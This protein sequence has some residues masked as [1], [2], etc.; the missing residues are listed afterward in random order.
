M[1]CPHCADLL[2]AY[3]RR[4]AELEEEVEFL[5]RELG[6]AADKLA[7]E[8]IS[9]AM[10]NRAGASRPAAART[11]AAL[12]AAKGRPLSRFDILERVPP[13]KE[14]HAD[15]LDRGANIASVWISCARKGLGPGVI[16]TVHGSGYRLTPEGMARVAAIVEG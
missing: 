15:P 3:D 12:Y 6:L 11:V 1:S 2:K 14:P 13:T 8:R 4:C 10:R 16:A 5:R 9:E 7:V